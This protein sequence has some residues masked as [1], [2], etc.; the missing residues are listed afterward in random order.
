MPNPTR[1][2]S[3]SFYFIFAKVNDRPVFLYIVTAS[4]AKIL[5]VSYKTPTLFIRQKRQK[6]LS[7][8]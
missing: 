4:K 3:D 6:S 1:R 2:I 8:L 5:R 7:N